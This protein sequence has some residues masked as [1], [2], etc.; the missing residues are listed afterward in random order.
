MPRRAKKLRCRRINH[1]IDAVPLHTDPATDFTNGDPSSPRG[2]LMDGAYG[3]VR[4]VPSL[5]LFPELNIL[6]GA[7]TRYACRN[8]GRWGEVQVHDS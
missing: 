5:T 3:G 7:L 8:I 1:N 6:G 4:L 2:M